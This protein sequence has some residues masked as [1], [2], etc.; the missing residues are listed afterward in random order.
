MKVLICGDSFAADWSPQYNQLSGWPN[1]LSNRHT[2]TNLAQAGVGEYKILK[3]LQSVD[4]NQYDALI[5][6]HT[7]PNRVHI[8]QHPVHYNSVLHKN[9]DLLFNDISAADKTNPVVDAAIGYFKYVFDET[10]YND[11]Y[12]LLVDESFRLTNN[13]NVL[14]ISFFE[15]IK[16]DYNF[17]SVFKENPGTANHMSARGNQQVFEFLNEWL[18]NDC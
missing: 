2:V 10:Y 13:C 14:H 18:K 5:V 6:S 8:E 3:Q 15:N 17:Y 9:C 1:L 16:V 4:L 7:S 12:Q 11:I